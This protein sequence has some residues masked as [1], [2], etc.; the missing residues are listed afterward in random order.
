MVRVRE[1]RLQKMQRRSWL[2][3]LQ[4]WIAR[5][6]SGV[7]MKNEESS[8]QP[9]GTSKKTERRGRGEMTTHHVVMKDL[10]GGRNIAFESLHVNI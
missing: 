9:R 1:R 10:S 6:R 3:H 8:Q 5:A 2:K 4:K 7:A